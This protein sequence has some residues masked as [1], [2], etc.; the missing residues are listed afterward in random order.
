MRAPLTIICAAFFLSGCSILNGRCLYETRNVSAQGVIGP[1]TV[2][3]VEHEQR[4]YQPD[5]DFQWQILG[6]TVKGDVS[7]MT[8][9]DATGKV[10]YTF[11]LDPAT[12]QQLSGGFVR[13]SEGAQINGFFDLLSS[14]H[15]SVVIVTRS[16]GT[17]TIPMQNVTSSD[18]TRPYCS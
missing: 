12:T 2:F 3:L 18:W 8:L 10:V 6:P 1:V 16:N 15:A 13:L 4:D 17:I 9:R 14:R 7:E 5:K 11:P